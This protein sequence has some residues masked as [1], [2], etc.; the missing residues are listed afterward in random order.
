[1]QK[2]IVDVGL[3]IVVTDEDIDDI[4]VSALEGGIDYWCKNVLVIRPYLGE[5][6]SEQISRGGI[7]IMYERE[8]DNRYFLTRAK[9]IDGLKMYIA[10]GNFRCVEKEIDD[11]SIYTGRLLLDPGEIDASAA[12]SIIQLALFGEIKFA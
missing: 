8:K 11:C 5:Y 1:M 7:L 6:A 12:D 9:F 10:S 2:A 3:H 4:M